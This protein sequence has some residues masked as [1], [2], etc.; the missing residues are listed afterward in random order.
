MIWF[1]RNL[2]EKLSTPAPAVALPPDEGAR[3]EEAL[4]WVAS[5]APHLEGD[6]LLDALAA[7]GYVDRATARRLLPCYRHFDADRH[8]SESLRR[9]SFRGPAAAGEFRDRVGRVMADLTESAALDDVGAEPA[10]RFR[11]G[12]R[13]GV[14][15]AYPMVNFTLG[16]ESLKA[17]EAVV[18]EMPDALVLVAR[19]FQD[20]TAQQLRA[21]LHRTEVP[22]T[23]VTVNLLLGIRAVT[24]K[25]QPG[26]DRVL[27]LLSAGRPLRTQDVA[28]LGDR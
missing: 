14:V 17:V 5:R 11:H 10:V 8:F 25:Y 26:G 27:D 7:T 16:G 1:G 4:R 19:N 2:S 18:E 21:L 3:M 23:L 6:A 12:A 28:T 13:E 24:L 9:L 15:L 22:G 20:G